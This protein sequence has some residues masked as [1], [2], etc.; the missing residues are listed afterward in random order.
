MTKHQMSEAA[1]VLHMKNYYMMYLLHV[2][3]SI[4]CLYVAILSVVL[5][6]VS[7]TVDDVD[8]EIAIELTHEVLRDLARLVASFKYSLFPLDMQTTNSVIS[9][10]LRCVVITCIVISYCC[11]LIHL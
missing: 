1:A 9:K 2:Q 4:I 8:S 7:F 5:F 11:V 6:Q 3:C 10:I